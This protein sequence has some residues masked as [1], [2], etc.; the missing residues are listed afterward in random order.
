MSRVE[1]AIDEYSA[2]VSP[3]VHEMAWR[4]VIFAPLRDRMGGAK[5][6]GKGNTL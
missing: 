1:T 5:V 2:A 6:G 4:R 3:V